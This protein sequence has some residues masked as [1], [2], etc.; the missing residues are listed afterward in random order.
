MKQI[1]KYISQISINNNQ[2]DVCVCVYPTRQSM[3][4]FVC[5]R[6]AN[7]RQNNVTLSVHA[8]LQEASSL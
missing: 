7:T 2:K 5:Q 6:Y 4:A 8:L 3:T 1:E